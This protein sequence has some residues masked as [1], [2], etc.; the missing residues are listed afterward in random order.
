MVFQ[1]SWLISAG[2]VGVELFVLRNRV[3]SLRWFPCSGFLPTA[4]GEL[5]LEPAA[6][7]STRSRLHDQWTLLGFLFGSGRVDLESKGSRW[8]YS[9][10]GGLKNMIFRRVRCGPKRIPRAYFGLKIGAFGAGRRE[11]S[12]ITIRTPKFP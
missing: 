6:A 7:A 3:Q 12:E 4:L 5:G 10:D 9:P 8:G 1:G 2:A 11:A